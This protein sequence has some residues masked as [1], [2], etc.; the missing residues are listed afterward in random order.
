[1]WIDSGQSLILKYKNRPTVVNTVLV[2]GL[3]R[4]RPSFWTNDIVAMIIS[5][6]CRE[7]AAAY[8]KCYYNYVSRQ[9]GLVDFDVRYFLEQF[10]ADTI[11]WRYRCPTRATAT[12]RP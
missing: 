5:R 9:K 6:P 1:M 2:V 11:A 4:V 8:L 10:P 3:I 7:A 12:M